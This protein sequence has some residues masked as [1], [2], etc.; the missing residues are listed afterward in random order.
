MQ[1]FV[2]KVP[3]RIRKIESQI[4]T[5]QKPDTLSGEQE[6][7]PENMTRE[8][9]VE[10]QKVK[11]LKDRIKILELELQRAR[12]ESFKA[13]YEEGKENTLNE[14]NKRIEQA[15]QEMARME[16]EYRESLERIEMPLLE[17]AKTMAMEV[18]ETELS[19]REDHD[20]ILL[21]RLRSMLREV[22]QEKK[23][24]VEVNPSHLP[25]LKST[26]IRQEL[27]LPREMEFT[28]LEGKHLHKGEAFVSSDDFYLDG[29]LKTQIEELGNKL[30]Q[31]E[32]L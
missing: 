24:T 3:K 2:I 20:Q 4:L 29:R 5:M 18:L 11:I 19:L 12:E 30:K 23:V 28:V 22:F 10:A 17:L 1:Q 13:G 6:P 8:A 25:F 9:L 32:S 27:D 14:A 26:D 16:K 7:N 21:K 15:R 31:G